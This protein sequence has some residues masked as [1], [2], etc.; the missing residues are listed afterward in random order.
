MRLYISYLHYPFNIS[1]TDT[2]ASSIGTY[3][4]RTRMRQTVLA[5]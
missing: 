3:I 2:F 1:H 4:L 5:R